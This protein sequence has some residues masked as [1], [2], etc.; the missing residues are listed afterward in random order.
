MEAHG[1]RISRSHPEGSLL[2]L[3]G[4]GK[5]PHGGGR[6]LEPGSRWYQLLQRWVSEG[7]AYD[8]DAGTIVSS[9]EVEPRQITLAP[10]PRSSCA[11]WL[12]ARMG[13]RHGVTAECDF[14]SNQDA[15]AS[16]DVTGTIAVTDVPGEAA[17]LVR[18]QG[19]WQSAVSHDLKRSDR[20]SDRL[21]GT[22]LTHWSGTSWIYS[23]FQSARPQMMRRFCGAFIWT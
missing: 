18:Y 3:K 21:S 6:K 8:S 14:Q 11:W 20:S 9:I 23:E 13:P 16:V 1:R 10:G 12:S 17:I 7:A 5:V 4:S 2:L 15:I 22:L 19:R